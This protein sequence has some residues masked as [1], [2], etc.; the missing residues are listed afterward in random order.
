MS[1]RRE[2]GA[3]PGGRHLKQVDGLGNVAQPLWAQ[4][5][6]VNP[7]E[8]TCGRTIEQDLAAVPARHH[9]RGAV[10]HRAEVVTAA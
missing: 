2:V 3:Q 1:Q 5:D 7:A 6:E 9:P 4:L 10:E 8:Q